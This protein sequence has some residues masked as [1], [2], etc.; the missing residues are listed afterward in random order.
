MKGVDFPCRHSSLLFYK[1]VTNPQK[2]NN[3]M[4]SLSRIAAFTASFLFALALAAQDNL[5]SSDSTVVSSPAAVDADST[6]YGREQVLAEATV[7]GSLP[8]TR[9]KGDAQHTTIAGTILEKIGTAAD[10]LN[11]VPT[12]KAGESG[13]EVVGRGNAEI[14]INGRK[15]LDAGEISR[16]RSDQIQSVDVIHNPGARYAATTKAVVRITLRKA[17]GEG[18]GFIENLEFVNRYN[19]T[20]H[21]NLDVNYRHGGFDLTASMW[22]GHFGQRSLQENDLTYFLGSDRVFA[23][24]ESDQK[25]YF[26]GYSPQLQFNYQANTNHSFGAFYKFDNNARQRMDGFFN[27]D[28]YLNDDF[29]ERSENDIFAKYTSLKHIFNGYYSGRFG[30]LSVDFSTEGQFDAT[31]NNN[32]SDEMT[33][34]AD[35]SQLYRSVKNSTHT[36]NDFAAAKLIFSYPV[37]RG[38]LSFGTEYSYNNRNEAYSNESR[39]G[40]GQVVQLPVKGIENTLRENAA[41]G[42]VEYGR[43]FGRLYAQAGLRYEHLSNDYFSAGVKQDDVC[44]TYSDLFP[45]AT[46]AMPVGRVQMSLSYRRDIQRPNYQNLSNSTIYLNAYTY[47]RGNP[48]L[49][50]MFTH[51]IVYN[52]GYREVNVMVNY[53]RVEGETTLITEPFFTDASDPDYNPLISLLHPANSKGYNR[54]FIA[55]SYRP[56]IGCWHPTWSASLVLQDYK[57]TRADGS[58]ITLN[59]PYFNLSWYND[60][61]LPWQLRLTVY[62]SYHTKGDYMNMHINNHAFSSFL[63]LQREFQTRRLGAF[64]ID[65]RFNDPFSSS[66]SD[67][68]VYGPRELTSYNPGHRSI[69]A[70]L[71]WKFNEARSKYK[72]QGAGAKQKARM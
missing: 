37:W 9:V 51:S 11:R 41:A 19:T 2:N 28:S 67:A 52:V 61:L 60:I 70:S 48:H 23:H 20:I 16:L 55:P 6:A 39:D 18:F 50:P 15:V 24:T 1:N 10:A 4:N 56:V 49:Q 64:N 66:A 53:S 26:N 32:E 62:A 13:I 8:R 36:D 33:T 35:H 21:D 22:G 65:V 17:Q 30:R 12:L 34:Y 40:Q 69:Q 25:G 29:F 44:R 68:I 54:L 47:Q 31:D 58:A 59:A 5:Q 45:S 46:L 63:G 27:T 7:K 57:T 43:S 71:T 72:G 3:K 14:Y 42:F 38:N